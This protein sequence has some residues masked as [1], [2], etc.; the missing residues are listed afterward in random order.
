MRGGGGQT[1]RRT[2]SSEKWEDTD[3]PTKEKEMGGSEETP[4]EGVREPGQG[5]KGQFCH[6]GSR[7]WGL[8]WSFAFSVGRSS[9]PLSALSLGVAV[10][11]RGRG[12]E[13]QV[14]GETVETLNAGQSSEKFGRVAARE[15]T[16]RRESCWFAYVTWR[17]GMHLSALRKGPA[18]RERK[19]PAAR[20]W[21]GCP[22]EEVPWL[23]AWGERWGV[24]QVESAGTPTS[25][26]VEPSLGILSEATGAGS[27]GTVP[28]T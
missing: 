5:K 16:G 23:R 4:G 12:R 13:D 28:G 7:S 20:F 1:P 21:S 9:C 22:R 25:G 8:H 11:G 14:G 3:K 6:R 18:E 26:G 17:D 10:T 24:E 15:D 2:S 27:C 19:Y